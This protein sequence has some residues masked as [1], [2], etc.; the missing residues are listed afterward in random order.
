MVL[1]DADAAQVAAPRRWPAGGRCGA[2]PR[3]AAAA[4]AAQPAQTDTARA[5]RA[6]T[7][8]S[9][10]RRARALIAASATF[11]RPSSRSSGTGSS[12]IRSSSI[13]RP[14]LREEERPRALAGTTARR[15]AAAP[16]VQRRAAARRT[17]RGRRAACRRRWR[18]PGRARHADRGERSVG[19][20]GDRFDVEPR[21]RGR[22]RMTT[23][24]SIPDGAE[25]GHRQ[26][27]ARLRRD[28][29]DLEA[30]EIGRRLLERLLDRELERRPTTPSSPSSCPAG[31]SARRRPRA[32]SSSTLPPWDSMYGRT[33]SSASCTRCSSGTGCRSWISS[34]VATSGSSASEAASR[35]PSGA[36][37]EQRA[38]D[39]LEPVAVHLHDRGHEL[40][41]QL[42]RAGLAGRVELR[43]ELLDALDA[44]RR[45][46]TSWPSRPRQPAV[47]VCITLRTLPAAGVHV[48]AARQARIERRGPP[49]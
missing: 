4:S 35:S 16:V 9:S 19:E 36:G 30:L 17:G 39:P 43:L 26:P 5:P 40:L 8:S 24:S 34:S 46:P 20:R 25:P 49:A 3:G 13:E 48:H 44:A 18:P 23:G 38:D 37:L 11:T 6:A 32:T 45:P 7:A 10:S 29:L 42:A 21:R 22:W 1:G 33:E 28:A 31:G 2:A 15:P 14:A 47:G 12:C 41:G 27:A